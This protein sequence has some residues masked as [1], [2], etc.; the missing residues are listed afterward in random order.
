MTFDKSL[1]ALKPD[2]SEDL[3]DKRLAQRGADLVSDILTNCSSNIAQISSNRSAQIGY[4]RFLNNERVKTADLVRSLV[5]PIR[6]RAMGKHV[7]V[8]QDTSEFNYQHHKR[9]IKTQTFGPTTCPSTPGF[10]VHPSLVID[11]KYKTLLGFSDVH[12]FKRDWDLP[13][14][15]VRKIESQPIEQK[16]SYRWITSA[17]RSQQVLDESTSMTIIGDRASDMYELFA[18]VP[19]HRTNLI[20]RCKVSRR[21]FP[22]GQKLY[23][24]IDQLPVAGEYSFK[25]AGL[26]RDKKHQRKQRK[27]VLEVRYSSVRI[28]RSKKLRVKAK[29][30]VDMWIVEVREKPESVPENEAPIHWRLLTT[31][32]VN[33]YAMARQIIEWYRQR[34]QIEQLF[35]VM[36]KKG[37]GLNRAK[38]KRCETM[39]KL[40]IM[41]LHPSIRILAASLAKEADPALEAGE[42]FSKKQIKLLSIML[43]KYE[44]KTIKQQNPY[45]DAS[46][47]WAA[48]IIARMGG[49]KGYLSQSKPGPNTMTRGLQKFESMFELFQILPNE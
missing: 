43:K 44:G 22:E 37:L 12:C 23:P 3:P 29:P 14:A 30:F 45:P 48:W 42:L 10:F 32:Q 35:R 19:D 18:R 40:V 4:Y 46:L 17:Y 5:K 6:H 27:A 21:L 25:V 7:L 49:W 28:R 16:E 20:V 31:H 38:F 24:F 47:Q 41:S 13:R 9:W 36:K 15:H 8:I 11:A 33:D 1:R 2:F 34:W 39:F 26:N